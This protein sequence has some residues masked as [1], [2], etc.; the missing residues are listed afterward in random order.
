LIPYLILIWFTAAIVLTSAGAQEA[1]SGRNRPT[2]DLSSE[3]DALTN[4]LKPADTSSPR[5]TLQSF[6]RDMD[7]ALGDFQES[8]MRNILRPVDAESPRATL[9]GFVDSVN[10]AY[11]LVME[12]NAALEADPPQITGNDARAAENVAM[13][14][15][16]HA[17]ATLDMSRTS[18]SIRDDVGME[19]VLQLKEILDRLVLPLIDSV[20]NLAMVRFERER[21]SKTTSSAFWPNLPLMK[22]NASTKGGS[23]VS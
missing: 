3:P 16:R 23:C 6:F 12:T 10:R 21:I 19:S 5:D 13:N 14:L 1:S 7:I 15:L 17:M 11:T 20:P 4:P 22:N 8:M 9:L 18:A 2:D